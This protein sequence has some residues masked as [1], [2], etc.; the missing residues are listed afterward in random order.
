MTSE[1]QKTVTLEIWCPILILINTA[2]GRVKEKNVKSDKRVA[3]SVFDNNNPY[4]MVVPL[5]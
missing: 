5:P 2:K 4:N 3:L 1:Q